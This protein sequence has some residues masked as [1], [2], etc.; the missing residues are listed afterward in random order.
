MRG[1]DEI[2]SEAKHNPVAST[3]VTESNTEEE[4]AALLIEPHRSLQRI[5]EGMIRSN[6]ALSELVDEVKLLRNS[7]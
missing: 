2:P 4:E 5:N 3:I 6:T 7:R 1:G